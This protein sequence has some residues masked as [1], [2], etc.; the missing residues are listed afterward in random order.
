MN[1]DDHR[2]YCLPWGT[3]AKRSTTSLKLHAILICLRR[4]PFPAKRALVRARARGGSSRRATCGFAEAR[5]V[6]IPSGLEALENP[7]AP[8]ELVTKSEH[9]R[10]DECSGLPLT[11]CRKIYRPLIYWHSSDGSKMIFFITRMPSGVHD[12]DELCEFHEE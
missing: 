12:A 1:I 7:D 4:F 11:R 8:G 9:K 3:F 10:T 2:S 5:R 6:L